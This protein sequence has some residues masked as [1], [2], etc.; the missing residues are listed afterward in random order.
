MGRS[1]EKFVRPEMLQLADDLQVGKV[2]VFIA[3]AKLRQLAE[4]TKRNRLQPYAAPT[5]RRMTAELG[6]EI[7]EYILAH[8]STRANREI[9]R[10][11]RVDGAR[12]SEAKN[13]WWGGW[14]GPAGPR[15]GTYAERNVFEPS[16][17]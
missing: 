5:S 14:Q 11:F 7:R 1:I 12:V 10:M 2:S 17:R 4:D 3:A 9:G 6:H 15:F 16:R 8:S 13:G